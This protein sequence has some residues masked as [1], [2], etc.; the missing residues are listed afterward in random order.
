M[1]SSRTSSA[2]RRLDAYDLAG[3]Q[4]LRERGWS[5]V[6][7]C[8]V[9]GS[10]VACLDRAFDLATRRLLWTRPEEILDGTPRHPLPPAIDG[11][12]V[13]V[14][15]FGLSSYLLVARDI[16]TGRELWLAEL[17]RSVRGQVD[18]LM[19]APVVGPNGMILAY[20]NVH[21]SDGGTGRLIA[22]RPDGRIA[23]SLAAP[24]T[25]TNYQR[26]ATQ[27]V[28]DDGV[29]YLGVG[30][31]V[32]AVSAEGRLLWELGEPEGV[33]E[34]A[35]VLAPAGDLAVH[36]DDVQLLVIATGSR[37]AARVPWPSANGGARNA[38]AR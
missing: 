7:E 20:V 31:A 34:S 10:T 11:D 26:F 2:T 9:R 28:D 21:R 29:V 13:Y 27:T 24:A 6:N 35:P 16:A 4:R 22:V 25:R 3:R 5:N 37:G 17:A 36:T 18:L 30:R 38:S 15:M 33:S 12:R 14:A 19:G 32:R 8:T 1:C 23:R